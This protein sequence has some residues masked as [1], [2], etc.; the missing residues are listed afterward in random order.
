MN[1]LLDETG[2]AVIDNSFSIRDTWQAMESLVDEGLVRSIGVSNW[3]V[4][5]LQELLSFAK[6]KPSLNQ[7][8]LHPY[9]IKRNN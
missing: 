1:Y 4:D 9:F 8:E 6:I 7:V 2:K 3:T 5:K